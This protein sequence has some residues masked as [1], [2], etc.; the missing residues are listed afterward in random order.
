MNFIF[1]VYTEKYSQTLVNSTNIRLYLPF[2]SMR[3]HRDNLIK[4]NR[5]QIVFI[6]C[7]INWNMV[8][9]IWFWVD[10]IRFR[11]NSSAS[12]Y[13]EIFRLL[14][15]E[16]TSGCIYH[17]GWCV[18]LFCLRKYHRDCDTAAVSV[19]DDWHFLCEHSYSSACVIF[20]FFFL[21]TDRCTAAWET[22]VSQHHGNIL[23]FSR[24]MSKQQHNANC[25]LLL[26]HSFDSNNI[27]YIA[28]IFVNELIWNL[29]G[30]D[31]FR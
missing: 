24:V 21:T 31:Y 22:C 28:W 3:T 1:D 15:I 18:A 16:P 7:Q 9:T 4:S 27:N 10:S 25:C 17:F 14:W 2:W 11:K 5:N 29:L 13:R 8:N 19:F 30:F 23:Y 26:K 12:I 6:I 20:T